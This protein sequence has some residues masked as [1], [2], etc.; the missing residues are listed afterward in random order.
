M[1]HTFMRI[2][3]E[4]LTETLGPGRVLVMDES[5]LKYELT[6]PMHAGSGKGRTVQDRK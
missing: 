4:H 6:M 5:S 1:S 2:S 3:Y